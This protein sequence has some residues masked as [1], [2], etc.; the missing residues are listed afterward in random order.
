M[1]TKKV[2]KNKIFIPVPPKIMEYVNDP[3]YKL[4]HKCQSYKPMVDFR[5]QK[6][7]KTCWSSF[8]KQPVL[9][10][11]CNAVIQKTSQTSHEKSFRH[12]KNLNEFINTSNSTFDFS[13]DCN[14]DFFIGEKDL[15]STKTINIPKL[16]NNKVEDMKSDNKRSGNIV[17]TDSETDCLN[18]NY[19]VNEDTPDN[20]SKIKKQT[21]S[22]HLF[23][24]NAFTYP[25]ENNNITSDKFNISIPQQNSDDSKDDLEIKNLDQALIDDVNKNINLNSRFQNLELNVVR[26]NGLC[27]FSDQP[28]VGEKTDSN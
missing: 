26:N 13:E 9:C 22:G 2:S 4:C 20:E 18:I 10:R 16:I 25:K 28:M 8:S 3:K 27:V 23:N 17:T 11:I 7:C 15:E 6:M 24:K 19:P 5:A 12:I 14:N 21:I 1:S